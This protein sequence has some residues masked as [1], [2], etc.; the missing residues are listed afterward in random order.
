[1]PR[2]EED[3]ATQLTPLPSTPAGTARAMVTLTSL[4]L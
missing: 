1:M 4:T 3:R 2:A